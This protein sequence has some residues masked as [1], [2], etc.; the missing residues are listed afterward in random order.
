[1]IAPSCSEAGRVA[2]SCLATR[3]VAS[4]SLYY[5]LLVG[6]VIHLLHEIVCGMGAI[7][8]EFVLTYSDLS[9][10]ALRGWRLVLRGCRSV[11]FSVGGCFFRWVE[12]CRFLALV[13]A[14]MLYGV[15]VPNLV[16]QN[17]KISV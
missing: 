2:I 15:L 12:G 4:V 13:C 14:L 6:L 9:L 1:M 8:C 7:S 10:V 11:P 3:M 16:S 5:A 17:F